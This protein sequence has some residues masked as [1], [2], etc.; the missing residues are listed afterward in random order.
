M[1]FV[2]SH[3]SPHRIHVHLGLWI[4]VQELTFIPVKFHLVHSSGKHLFGAHAVQ[5]TGDTAQKGKSPALQ[6]PTLSLTGGSDHQ[7]VRACYVPGT[8]LGAA[9]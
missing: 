7:L 5:G 4:Q 9:Q 1:L 2:G 8:V 6:E 3:L